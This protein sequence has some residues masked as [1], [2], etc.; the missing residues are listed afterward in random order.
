MFFP[1]KHHGVLA[2]G[3][4]ELASFFGHFK[5]LA[6]PLIKALGVGPVDVG[7]GDAFDGPR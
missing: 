3:L 6:F 2:C 5:G 7:A 4:S 1:G